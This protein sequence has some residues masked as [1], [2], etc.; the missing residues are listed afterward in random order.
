MLRR[1]KLICSIRNKQIILW[2]LFINVNDNKKYHLVTLL[3]EHPVYGAIVQTYGIMYGEYSP[4]GN[5][6]Q[7][8]KNNTSP[9]E[10]LAKRLI[11]A[12]TAFD[13]LKNISKYIV[14]NNQLK[15]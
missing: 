6:K 9:M 7:T 11:N 2:S 15:R 12:A 13:I 3:L 14:E 1:K 4:G 8:P 5:C 10:S